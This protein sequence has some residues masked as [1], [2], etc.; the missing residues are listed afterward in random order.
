V[1]VRERVQR[2]IESPVT[3]A[4]RV[5]AATP[6]AKPHERL[7]IQMTGW[8]R[9]IAGAL[10]ELAIELESLRA[11]KPTAAAEPAPRAQPRGDD[12]QP[13]E[14]GR[15]Q[16]EDR[17]EAGA[18]E[19]ALAERARASRAETEAVREERDSRAEGGAPSGEP[20]PRAS[21]PPAEEP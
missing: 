17:D 19:A 16:P 7:S 14:K 15:E 13:A 5:L 9:G 1:G 20:A 3:E 4:E 6:H 12:E 2:A 21:T 8:F 18:S 11:A 10:E